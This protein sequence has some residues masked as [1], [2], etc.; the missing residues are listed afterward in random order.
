MTEHLDF[1]GR[2][3]DTLKETTDNNTSVVQKLV[4]QQNN[5]VVTVEKMPIGEI[6]QELKDH[7][8]DAHDERKEILN[9]VE[10]KTDKV[11][12]KMKKVVSDVNELSGKIK[13]MIA[14]VV[15][16]VALTG[17]AYFVGRFLVDTSM[18]KKQLTTIEEK[19]QKEQE[20]EHKKLRKEVIEVIREELRKNNPDV[21]NS[22][23]K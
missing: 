8:V 1:I 9:M 14:V 11:L 3:F 16:A 12:D 7:V 15:I 13:L 2:L 18:S 10:T 22:D 5:L 19:I 17:V 23:Q 21:Y 20:S 6:R 4:D